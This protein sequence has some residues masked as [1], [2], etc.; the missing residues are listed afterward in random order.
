MSASFFRLPKDPEPIYDASAGL[1]PS[2]EIV[3]QSDGAQLLYHLQQHTQ[4]NACVVQFVACHRGDGTSTITRDLA[5]IGASLGLKVLLLDLGQTRN[6]QTRNDQV[7]NDQAR[8]DQARNDRARNDQSSGGGLS[9]ADWLR[10]RRGSAT[11]RPWQPIASPFVNSRTTSMPAGVHIL[12]AGMTGLH[13]SELTE[14]W[15]PTPTF[16]TE[17]FRALRT[18]FDIVLVDSSPLDQSADGLLLAQYVSTT[19]LVVAA[20]STRLKVAEDMRNR[21]T[22]VGGDIAGLTLNRRRFHIPRWIYD[23]F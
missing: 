18:S 4:P 2:P 21:I 8:N 22:E 16:C 10:N 20:E 13:V 11:L 9:Q 6:D 17:L 12:Q 19:V 23:W 15:M 7:R 14:P 3:S 5:C 1:T